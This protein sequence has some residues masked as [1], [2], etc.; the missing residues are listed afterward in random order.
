[1][2][3]SPK[4]AESSSGGCSPSHIRRPIASKAQ[5]GEIPIDRAHTTEPFNWNLTLA[6][7]DQKFHLYSDQNPRTAPLLFA[8]IPFLCP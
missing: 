8:K 4:G 2:S 6:N 7:T 5:R 3:E 1:M